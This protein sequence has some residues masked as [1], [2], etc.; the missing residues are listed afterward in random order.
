MAPVEVDVG[1]EYE[2][3]WES[4]RGAGYVR[5]R[6]DGETHS[7]DKTPTIDRRRKHAVEVLV[8]RVVARADAR[9][10]IAGSVENALAL[11][12]GVVHVA[13]P[14]DDVPE[15]RW[16]VRVHSQHL[17]CEQCG[18]SFDTLNPHNFSF[19]STLG[20]CPAC[21]GLGTQIGANP[22]ALMRDANLPLAK[23][24]LLVW[25]NVSL[26][27][28]QQMLSALS[29][30]SGVPID[31]PYNDLSPRQRRTVLFGTGDEWI[32]VYDSKRARSSSPP[33][34]AE[35]RPA[36]AASQ[37][38]RPLFRFQYKG[39]YPALEEASKLSPKLRTLLEQFVGEIDCSECGGS[40]LR[41]DAAA[42]RFRD[43]TLDQ[44]GRAPLG[45]LLSQVKTWKL[46][47]NEKK[48]AGEL[49]R[50]I[51]NRLTFLVDVGLDYLTLGRAAPTLSG[52]E[53]QRIRLASQV[54]SGLCGVLYV[55][56]EPTI[57]LHPRDNARLVTALKKL[58]DLGNTLLIVEHDREVI[59]NSDG[60]FDFGPGAGRL[61]G[62]IVASG[63]PEKIAK[64]RGSVTGPYLSGKKAI[65]VPTNRRTDIPVRSLDARDRRTVNIVRP[66]DDLPCLEVVGARHN[67]LKN[68]NV[69]IPLGT[70]TA[71]TGV[72][73]SGKSSLVED[74]LYNQLAKTLHRASTVPGAHESIRGIEHINKVIRVDQQPLGNTPTSNPA[75]YTGV[76]ELIR[77]LFSQLPESKLRGYS[78]RQ[79]SFN[80][81]GGRCEA[82]EGNGQICIQM[83]FLPDVWVECE[84]C[85]GLRYNPDVLDV[86][87]HGKSIADVLAMS[88]GQAV[89]L[90]GNI[91][92]VRRI[93]QTLCDVG[94]DYLTLGQSAPSLS[95]GE[96]QRVKLAAEL[97][98]P[99]TGQT[100]YLLDEPTTGLHFDDS[101]KVAR[102]AQSA[103]GPRQHGRR[104]RAQSRCH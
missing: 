39:L 101:G 44:I 98:R 58:R 28:S 36:R 5:V 81:P 77:H 47:A 66:T 29:A 56:D 19:N 59:A 103:R 54:G 97:A 82:C 2:T 94:L 9:S 17:A 67:N 15:S 52:G 100:L 75:T 24:A 42:F 76:F 55:L 40:R 7:L 79:F 37:T 50:E 91:P 80:V 43:R 33:T 3:L 74:I 88:C 84:T 104:D 49:I 99:D 18:R 11:G 87:F 8:D 26:A 60:L 96:A 38:D 20:W 73:G 89:D 45:E 48:V 93:L 10:R 4:L 63:T 31:V 16:P 13:H 102:C 68:I 25:P 41:D 65:A 32:D 78:A 95:G 46:A 69:R 27:M 83:H 23:G 1:E 64:Q 85:R 71:V 12:K 61:G 35:N 22:A 51:D 70:L 86:R 30:H 6:V 21:E 72:S 14:A 90:F 53:A 92:K 34:G 62:Q 57:G